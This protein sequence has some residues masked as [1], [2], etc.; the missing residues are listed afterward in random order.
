ME[1]KVP[2]LKKKYLDICRPALLKEFGYT[3]GMQVPKIKKIILN[4]GVGEAI[5]DKKIINKAQEELTLIAGQKAVQTLSKKNI[6]NFKLRI[7]VPIG[8]RVTL[9]H[10]KMYEFLEK[11]LFVAIPAIKDFRGVA[12]KFDGNGNYTLGI[13]EQTIF[14]EIEVDKI[15][16][17]IGMNITIVTSAES[18]E[19]GYALLKNLGFPFKK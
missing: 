12:K 2:V 14:P 7:D 17:Y 6:S 16:R 5:T 18:D 10:N 11:L 8:V 3:S 9:R 13:E 1:N 4:Q 15:E 19:E